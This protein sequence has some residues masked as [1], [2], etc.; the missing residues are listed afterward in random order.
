[1]KCKHGI[2]DCK[3]DG[4]EEI[5]WVCNIK[6]FMGA[7]EYEPE[8]ENANSGYP[9]LADGSKFNIKE[10]LTEYTQYL[11]DCNYLDDDWWCEDPGSVEAFLKEK[12]GNVS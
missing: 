12:F 6:D 2:K 9:L 3:N 10:L 11:Y 5:C 4:K 8:K 1:M 7:P